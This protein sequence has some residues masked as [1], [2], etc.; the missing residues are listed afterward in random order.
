MGTKGNPSPA[1]APEQPTANASFWARARRPLQR[2]PAFPWDNTVLL[3]LAA[4]IGIYAGIA[5]GLF[6][7][8]IRTVQIVLFKFPELTSALFGRGDQWRALAWRRLRAAPWHPEFAVLAGLIIAASLGISWLAEHR[9]VRVPIFEAHRLRS[10]GVAG[11]FGLSLFYPLLLLRTF[12][13]TF[14]E[15]EGGLFEMLVAVPLWLRILAPALGGLAAG[16]VVRYV[17][18]ESAGHGVVEVIEAVHSR[19]DKLRGHVALWKSV[20]AGLVIGSGGSAGREG[21][22]V[23]VGGSVAASLARTLKIP[24]EGAALLMACGAAAG[25]AASF[26]APLAGTLFALEI[27][28]G[29]F[30]ARRFTPVVLASVC[31]TVTSRALLGGGSDLR[32]VAWVLHSPVEMALYVV[33]GLIAGGCA[34]LYV[35]ANHLAEELFE[36]HS[37]RFGA[38][39][40]VARRVPPA[41]KPMLGGLL[42]GAVALAAPRAMGTGTESMNAALAGQLALGALVL[43]LVVKLVATALTLGS[44]APG[45]SFFPAV[46]LGAMLGGAFGQ[47]AR[48]VFGSTIAGPEAYAAVGMGAVVAGATVAPLT[49]VLMMFELTGSYQIVLPLLVSCGI[50]TALVVGKLG[51]SMYALKA[52][53]RGVR[54]GRVPSAL[55][56]LSVATA[57]ERLEPLR[58]DLPFADLVRRVA[59]SSHPAFPIVDG[60]GK[61]LGV[62]SVREV[63]A[64]LLDHALEDLAVAG[65]FAHPVRTLLLDDTLELALDQLDSSGA[66]AVV[67]E[68]G[69]EGQATAVGILTRESVLDAWHRASEET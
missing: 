41:L 21:P 56:G 42:V 68:P 36:G 4:V 22:V 63:R 51:G 37:S 15:S 62:L 52:R 57:V 31:A 14:H 20:A 44:G 3:S 1:V 8:C 49:G 28:L 25:I 32:P 61:L 10:A 13:G 65:D 9:R 69:A 40:Q 35:R 58:A 55:R 27:V 18:P 53:A 23:H 24:R 43:A 48:L 29:D 46:F 6:A 64:A 16:L 38:L 11:A 50:A 67:L 34:I 45:G 19:G 60:A 33:L 5:A 7:S 54:P 47:V 66:E 59:E 12:N 30:S 2:G 39:G 17:S 26:H